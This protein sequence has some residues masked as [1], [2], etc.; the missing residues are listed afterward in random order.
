MSLVEEFFK[1]YDE[2]SGRY[3]KESNIFRSQDVERPENVA[4]QISLSRR[5]NMMPSPIYLIY[6][7]GL[8]DDEF[9]LDCMDYYL[10]NA[11]RISRVAREAREQFAEGADSPTESIILKKPSKRRVAI[12]EY[13]KERALK[14]GL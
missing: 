1:Q 4:A 7:D 2:L 12:K 11:Q 3:G 5:K 14:L 9:L 8:L 6:L 13:Y 10:A